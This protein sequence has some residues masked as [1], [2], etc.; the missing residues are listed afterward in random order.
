MSLDKN[1]KGVVINDRKCP[2]CGGTPIMEEMYGMLYVECGKCQYFSG[3]YSKTEEGAK[4]SWDLLCRG[5]RE[6]YI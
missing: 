4:W 5:F 6:D 2:E 1:H 3:K